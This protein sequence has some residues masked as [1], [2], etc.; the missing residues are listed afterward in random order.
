MKCSTFSL[1]GSI[2]N[3][4]VL[5]NGFEVWSIAKTD[6]KARSMKKCLAKQLSKQVSWLAAE[7]GCSGLVIYF[8]KHL[9]YS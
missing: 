1:T 5:D 2:G 6:K 3:S 4:Q 8:A 7:A 9:P